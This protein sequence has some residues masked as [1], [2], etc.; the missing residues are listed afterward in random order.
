MSKIA[1]LILVLAMV[2][3]LTA[4]NNHENTQDN[5]IDVS[6]PVSNHSG[7]YSENSTNSDNQTST[8]QVQID[9]KTKL[10]IDTFSLDSFTAPDG[11]TVSKSD[12]VFA[13]GDEEHTFAV[14]FDFSYMRYAKP[15][16]TTTF[17]DPSLIDWETF[18]LKNEPYAPVEAPN[19]FKI[20][21]GD[22]LDNGLKVETAKYWVNASGE[23][24]ESEI[25][26]NGDLTLDGVLY[27][28]AGDPDYIDAK[29]DLLFFSDTTKSSL[30]PTPKDLFD[31]IDCHINTMDN[32][33]VYFDGK[34]IRLGNINEV[35]VDLFD[36]FDSGN[37]IK[38]KI[39]MRGMRLMYNDN[40]GAFIFAEPVSVE[41][42]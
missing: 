22:I 17:D 31:F 19:Y 36:K 6:T 33:A 12:A 29:G 1:S 21:A 18:E 11:N 20:K 35:S 37:Y 2:A 34:V 42:L 40:G 9:A 23:I 4:C 30:I 3:G 26:L 14:G 13:L 32:F 5:S 39:T 16:F 10:M 8:P 7:I 24:Y 27:C 15:I 41:K 28:I 38:A 25:V